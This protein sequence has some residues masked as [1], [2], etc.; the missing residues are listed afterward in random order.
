[1]KKISNKN[2]AIYLF[3]IIA[4]SSCSPLGDKKKEFLIDDFTRHSRDSLSISNNDKHAYSTYYYKL[5][6]Q[7]NDT[8]LVGSSDPLIGH[9]LIGEIDTT[10]RTDFYGHGTVFFDLY[11]YKAN[12]GS[13]RVTMKVF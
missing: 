5:Q 6:G 3:I 8:I 9:K 13:L 4:Y 12:N 2:L 10:F 11:P 7:V 1:M